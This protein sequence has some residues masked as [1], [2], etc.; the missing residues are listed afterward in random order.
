MSILAFSTSVLTWPVFP[1]EGKQTDIRRPEGGGRTVKH[2]LK[3]FNLRK[4]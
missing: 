1:I 4:N 2:N 3:L